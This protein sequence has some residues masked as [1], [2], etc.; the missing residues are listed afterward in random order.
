MADDLA[1]KQSLR[2]ANATIERLQSELTQAKQSSAPSSSGSSERRDDGEVGVRRSQ[3]AA[4]V[5]KFNHVSEDL[6]RIMADD[7]EAK[8]ALRNA[9]LEIERLRDEVSRPTSVV[10]D[11]ELREGSG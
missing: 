7:I 2:D 3:L 10:N 11:K 4:E 1:A 5:D 9:N 8:N 6:E